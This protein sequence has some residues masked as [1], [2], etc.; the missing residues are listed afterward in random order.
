MQY[1]IRKESMSNKIPINTRVLSRIF[2]P[3]SFWLNRKNFHR[4][5]NYDIDELPKISIIT[6][7]LLNN[8]NIQR[9]VLSLLWQNY[10]K[11]EILI[12]EKREGTKNKAFI[13]N[14]INKYPGIVKSVI[15]EN[16]CNQAEMINKGLQ[17][18]NGKIFNWLKNGDTIE[19]NALFNIGRNVMENKDYSG[20]VGGCRLIDLFGRTVGYVFSNNLERENIGYFWQGSHFQQSAN[21]LNKDVVDQAGV[22]DYTLEYAYGFDLW[23]RISKIKKFYRVNDVFAATVVSGKHENSSIARMKQNEIMIVKKKYRFTTDNVV[24]GAYKC[25]N[26]NVKKFYELYEMSHLNYASEKIR[27]DDY[28]MQGLRIC[29]VS[30][31]LP[32]YDKT[33]AHL[34]IYNILKILK[35]LGFKITFFYSLKTDDDKKYINDLRNGVD[36]RFSRRYVDDDL[37]T[38][39][40]EKSNYVWITSI[41][42]VADFVWARILA[43]KIRAKK[44]YVKII[45]DTMDFHYKRMERK[46]QN[47]KNADL[48]NN[49]LK[50]F[51]LEKEMYQNSDAV[52]VVTEK[53]QKDIKK[54]LKINGSIFVIPN[55][56]KTYQRNLEYKSTRNFCYLGNFEYA[57]NNDAALY[58]IDNIFPKILKRIPE[59][60]FHV[61]GNKSRLIRLKKKNKNVKLIGFI[62]NL[63]QYLMQ[64][65][66]FAGYI[67]YGS[68]MKGKIASAASVGLPIVTTKIGAEG[69]P[70][71]DGDNCFL[72]DKK[73]EFVEKCIQLYRDE[74]L[75]KNF[76]VKSKCVIQANYGHKI[77]KEKIK[78]LFKNV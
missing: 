8:C 7:S 5:F 28:N 1:H 17:V 54:A 35:E 76:S 39:A 9:T 74:I 48:K 27:N 18:S 34:R 4:A 26:D 21:F 52:V 78:F 24:P 61:I 71:V 56:H 23:I 11:I 60:E 40:S 43:N 62:E 64:Y 32:R 68:G 42:D 65:R 58:F 57:P 30:N 2:L 49:A 15:A 41:W 66:I 14:C 55:I 53:E 20:W 51:D 12:V 72:A 31:Y 3:I 6:I 73:T 46:Y 45:T 67:R 47:I 70:F 69:M 19:P 22:L 13:N 36:L 77:V 16:S 50:L 25:M 44:N 38:Q 37:I 75:W 29:V 59:T 63:E 10:P 33:S